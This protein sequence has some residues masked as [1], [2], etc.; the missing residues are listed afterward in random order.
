MNCFN[1]NEKQALG[2]C[3]H[4]NKGI[5][6]EC[7]TDLGDGLACTATCIEEVQTINKLI[8]HN[9]KAS[10]TTTG[11]WKMTGAFYMVVGTLFMT[12]SIFYFR[13]PD[14]FLIGLGLIFV[15]FGLY[16][17]LKSRIYKVKNDDF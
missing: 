6:M 12:T 4:C 16:S 11:T 5:C 13:K 14:V 15:L 3:K 8:N 17:V 1:H 10:K 9:K 2:I 7:L